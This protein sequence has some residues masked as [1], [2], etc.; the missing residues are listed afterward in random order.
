MTEN[1][2]KFYKDLIE[3]LNVLCI[4]IVRE[5]KCVKELKKIGSG[6]FGKVMSGSFLTLPIAIKKMKNFKYEEFYKEINMIRRFNHKYVPSLYFII[7]QRC[8][9][10]IVSELVNGKTLDEY[11]KKTRPTEIQ[12][13]VHLLDLATVL[14]HLHHYNIIHRDLKPSNVMIDQHLEL[15]LIDFGI[16]KITQNRSFTTTVAMG[17]ILYMAPENFDTQFM[18]GQTLN[19]VMKSKITGRVDVWAFGC[20]L[21]EI[22]SKVK[23]WF[24]VAKDDNAVIS[25]L[26][27]KRNFP[28][29]EKI[30]NQKIRSLIENCTNVIECDRYNFYM[31]II[32]LRDILFDMVKDSLVN[33]DD[34]HKYLK[35][36]MSKKSI[37]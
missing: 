2:E 9:L 30:S 14:N 18:K 8:D 24:P 23:P 15:K 37:Y 21:S 20:I 13:I 19:E 7:K 35:A 27:N 12:I 1:S 3:R 25:Q 6:G 16:S 26:Y 32:S 22:F 5:S 33:F 31:T 36:F 34:Q 29:P 10:N 11:I 4:D 28:V 17:T